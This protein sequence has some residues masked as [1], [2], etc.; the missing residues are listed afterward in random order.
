MLNKSSVIVYKITVLV[1]IATIVI[2]LVRVYEIT[3][4]VRN[5]NSEH[6]NDDKNG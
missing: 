3:V 2:L 1:I 5:T 4:L 6:N